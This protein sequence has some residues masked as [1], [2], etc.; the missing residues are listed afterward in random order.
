MPNFA[1]DIQDFVN[2]V[3]LF[4]PALSGVTFCAV[5]VVEHVSAPNIRTLMLADLFSFGCC[6]DGDAPLW[7][8]VHDLR[9]GYG[10]GHVSVQ[11]RTFRDCGYTCSCH[12]QVVVE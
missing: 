10:D 6:C 7:A 4:P 8:D 12:G 1:S 2:Q 3:E 5:D 9:L 11:A